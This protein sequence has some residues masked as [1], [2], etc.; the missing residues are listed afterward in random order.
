MAS[1]R[2][3][4]IFTC[5]LARGV[6]GRRAVD[7]FVIPFPYFCD[8]DVLRY[9]HRKGAPGKSRTIFFEITTQPCRGSDEVFV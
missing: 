9:P 1:S 5:T 3:A 7:P 8:W 4:Y 2:W 6:G